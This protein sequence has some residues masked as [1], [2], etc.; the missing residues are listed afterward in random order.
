MTLADLLLAAFGLLALGA[1]VAVV[2]T[3]PLVRAGRW[4]AVGWLAWIRR[5]KYDS[6]NH[7][8]RLLIK[9]IMR[10]NK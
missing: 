8:L 6:R 5:Q 7:L 4:L 1:A 3:P 9:V 10:V 2:P